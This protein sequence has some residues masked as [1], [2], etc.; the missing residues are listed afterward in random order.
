MRGSFDEGWVK[1]PPGE[2]DRLTARVQGRRRSQRFTNVVA[3]LISSGVLAGM[4]G[5]AGFLASRALGYSIF[6]DSANTSN[7]RPAPGVV[8]PKTGR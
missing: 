1:C 6:P 4:L 5:L 8:S 7:H 2:L 3:A